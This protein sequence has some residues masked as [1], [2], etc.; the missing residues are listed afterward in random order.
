MVSVHSCGGCDQGYGDHLPTYRKRTDNCGD[1]THG[2][3]VTCG[4]RDHDTD[5]QSSNCGEHACCM[6]T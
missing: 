5:D 6:V 3:V 1:T 2:Y 4:R